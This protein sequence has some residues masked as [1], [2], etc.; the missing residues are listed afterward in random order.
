M[1]Y[2]AW[3]LLATFVVLVL[4]CLLLRP[5]RSVSAG[6]TIG[7]APDRIFPLIADLK[8]GWSQWSPLVPT[9]EGITL[10]F[11]EPTEGDGAIVRWQGKAGAG[12]LI[13]TA[14]SPLRHVSYETRM[15]IGSMSASGKISLEA[16]GSSTTVTWSDALV[17]GGN[18]VWRWLGFAMDSMRRNNVKA[19]LA[20]LKRVV[21]STPK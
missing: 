8:T 20:A 7:A 14:S 1:I 15:G 5:E 12:S 18:P 17:I 4:G 19:G 11:S 10:E 3:V 2:L 13:I 16:D 6:V 9:S 21:E